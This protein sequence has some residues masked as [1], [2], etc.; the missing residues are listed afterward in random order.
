[1]FKNP[2]RGYDKDH[3]ANDLLKLKSF[4]SSQNKFEVVTKN[5]FVTMAATKTYPF[6]TFK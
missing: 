1:L 6:K 2:P 4:E 5:D 3:P